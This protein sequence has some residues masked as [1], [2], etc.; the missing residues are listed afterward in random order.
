MMTAVASCTVNIPKL[1]PMIGL[2]QDQGKIPVLSEEQQ[3]QERCTTNSK[4]NRA[5]G[6]QITINKGD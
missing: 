5:D 1:S 6:V 2:R 3:D 4:L